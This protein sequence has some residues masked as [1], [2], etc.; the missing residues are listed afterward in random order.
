[1]LTLHS[2]FRGIPLILE[3]QDQIKPGEE[4]NRKTSVHLQIEGGVVLLGR[5]NRVASTYQSSSG[6][7]AANH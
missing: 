2:I 6:V 7:E 1:M 3:N 5:S 4:R